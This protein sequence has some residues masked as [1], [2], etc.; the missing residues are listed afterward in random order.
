MGYLKSFLQYCLANM[1]S[2][3]RVLRVEPLLQCL[4]KSPECGVTSLVLLFSL[5]S[6]RVEV[7]LFRRGH[8]LT[9]SHDFPSLSSQWN[10]TFL[11]QKRQ[12]N[13]Y[14]RGSCRLFPFHRSM[15]K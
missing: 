6:A 15:R 12:L 14:V 5:A 10:P 9:L 7:H 4:N 1:S 3:M 11:L 8:F 2:Q 13:R